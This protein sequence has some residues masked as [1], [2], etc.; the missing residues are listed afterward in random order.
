MKQ[1][2]WWV[3]LAAGAALAFLVWLKAD[4]LLARANRLILESPDRVEGLQ[5]GPVIDALEIGPGDVVVDLGSG[6]GVFT[7]P[8]ARAVG[9]AGVVYAV[10]INPEL[11]AMVEESAKSLGLGNIRTILAD[12][13]DPRIPEPADLILICDTLHHIEGR[14]EYVRTLRRYL[15]PSGVLAVIDFRQGESPHLSSSMRY[16]LGELDGWMEAAG[17]EPAGRHD[18]LEDN[19]FVVY[20]CPSCPGGPDE[21]SLPAAPPPGALD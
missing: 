10:D 3:L 21:R 6:T 17:Y 20:E 14:A 4:W 15:R 18:F 2:T 13:D 11:L 1:R 19:F 8:L 9:D 16:S 12:E 7:R 5:I